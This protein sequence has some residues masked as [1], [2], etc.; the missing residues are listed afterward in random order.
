MTPTPDERDTVTISESVR[1]AI[2]SHAAKAYPHEC[3][4]ALLG[5]RDEG[6][7]DAIPFDNV[8]PGDRDRRFLV[9]AADYRAAESRADRTG[10]ALL[11]F[12]HSHPDHPAEP[13]AFDLAHAWPNLSYVILSVRD[14]R[15]GD[16]KS[17]RLDPDRS[18]F[19]EETLAPSGLQG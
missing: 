10:R 1:E 14:G 13:S 5:S 15:P 9:S 6:I 19:A 3:C 12:Y 8:S 16:M 4:G 11:G 18:R 7:E 2:R 17:W